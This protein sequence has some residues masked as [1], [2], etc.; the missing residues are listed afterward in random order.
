MMA[1]LEVSGMTMRD[2]TSGEAARAL[3]VC[4]ETIRRYVRQGRLRAKKTLGG[5]LRIPESEI[6]RALAGEDVQPD[7][8]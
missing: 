5:S 1:K 2:Y 3:G 8:D 7:A 4:G 6:R